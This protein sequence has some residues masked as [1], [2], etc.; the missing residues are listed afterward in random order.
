MSP[1]LTRAAFDNSDWLYELKWDGY[2]AITE[3]QGG[4]VRFYSRN[5]R[6]FDRRFNPVIESLKKIRHEAI[7]DGELVAV[8]ERG[9]A[10]FEWLQT[11]PR[12]GGQLAYYVFDLLY[13]DGYDLCGLP[14]ES[15]KALLSKVLPNLPRVKLCEHIE[16][17]G[18]AFFELSGKMGLEGIVAKHR[19]SL[20][21][22]GQRAN[23]WRKIKHRRR[24]ELVIR[25]FTK[26]PT[27][28][29]VGVER[30]GELRFAGQVEFGFS[31]QEI[32]EFGP[33]LDRIGTERLPLRKATPNG[34]LA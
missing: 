28:I 16:G 5:L 14:L 4:A 30:D 26:H 10:R 13:L 9:I 33:T 3:V 12:F 15:R 18:K 6:P 23:T 19:K 7:F 11:Y 22:P 21:R 25:G 1:T 27:S 2:R 20:Y 34:I 29:L 8:D 31:R 24:V 32:T 17:Q